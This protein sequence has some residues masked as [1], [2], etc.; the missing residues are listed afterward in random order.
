MALIDRIHDVPQIDR[1]AYTSF[2][3][4]GRRLG[5]IKPGFEDTLARFPDVFVITDD[6][7]TLQPALDDRPSRTAA[8]NGC[9][10]VLRTEGHLPK[11]RGEQYPA[12]EAFHAPPAMT[13]ERAAAPLFGTRHYGVHVNGFVRGPGGGVDVWVAKRSETKQTDPG[14]LDQIAAGGQPIGIGFFDNVVKECQEE[15]GIPPEL[16]TTAHAVSAVSYLT[17]WADGMHNDVAVIFD[18]ELPQDFTPA[19]TD[20]EVSE[21]MLWPAER[22]RETLEAGPAFAPDSALVAID[23]L[24]RHGFVA[25]DEPDFEAIVRGLRR[26]PL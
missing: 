3:I 20:G 21:F 12:T 1:E 25:A 2:I 24:V 19:N 6:G 10:E 13:L 22:L 23:F 26:A 16:S 11:W 5:L 9:L 18:L 8:V 14:K 15:A 4:D 7:V 17:E